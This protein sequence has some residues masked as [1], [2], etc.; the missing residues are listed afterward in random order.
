M[1]RA[2]GDVTP[3]P[4]PRWVLTVDWL[5]RVRGGPERL[6]QGVILDRGLIPHADGSAATVV[7]RIQDLD[8]N[9][10]VYLPPERLRVIGAFTEDQLAAR[11]RSD[12]RVD[13]EDGPKAAVDPPGPSPTDPPHP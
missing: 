13:L 12:Q 11:P 2:A 4:R 1:D 6:R 5:E 3:L 8:N 10:I 9:E 7:C